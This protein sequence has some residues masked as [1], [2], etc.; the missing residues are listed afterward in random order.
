MQEAL[1][2]TRQLNPL[3]LRLVTRLRP[4]ALTVFGA[5]LLLLASPVA[6]VAHEIP[7]SVTI[8]AFLKPDGRV[9]RIVARVPLEAMR[10]IQWPL[11]GRATSS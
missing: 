2:P 8:L 10:D 4:V 1:L 9:L 7:K 5:L 6:G 11:R 3:I